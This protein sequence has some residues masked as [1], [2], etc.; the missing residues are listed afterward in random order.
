MS[1]LS[2][3]NRVLMHV[4]TVGTAV[5]T[6]PPPINSHNPPKKQYEIRHATTDESTSKKSKQLQ[7]YLK[8]KCTSKKSTQMQISSHLQK[9]ITSKKKT[10]KC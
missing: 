5:R 2:R 9:K 6:L 8:K 1:L 7:T 4:K 10:Y 3:R